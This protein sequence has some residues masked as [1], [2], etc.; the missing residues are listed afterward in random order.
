[1]LK[2]RSLGSGPPLVALHG[3]THTGEQYRSLAMAI[4]RQIL[5]PDLPGHG[6]SADEPTQIVEVISALAATIGEAG[7]AVPVLGYS[8]GARLALVLATGTSRINGPLILISG[9][10]GIENEADRRG[11]RDWDRSTGD[12]IIEIG[13]ER[14]IDDWT[15]GGMTSTV[16][17]P[18]SLRKTD[19]E[20]RLE[21]TA[22]GLASA[23]TGY[24]TGVM[25]SVW[26]LLSSITVPTL[27]LTGSEDERYSDIGARM[28]HA[29]GSNAVHEVIAG[30][31]HD[32]LLSGPTKTAASIQNFLAG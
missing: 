32:L 17:L 13:M 9:T 27:I 10:A 31:G 2:A 21:N 11:R 14:F 22:Q 18:S 28:A 5:A 1:V 26:H 15:S 3:F 8:Q 19:R 4:D 16:D 12:R 24:G 20:E 7:E 6:A 23:L 29:I 25:P 30:G